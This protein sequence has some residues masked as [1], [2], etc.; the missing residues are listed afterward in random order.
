MLVLPGARLMTIR[1]A[2]AYL[3]FA[4]AAALAAG[5]HAVAEP[6]VTQKIVTYDVTGTTPAEVRASLNQ[7]GPVDRHDSRRYDANTNWYVRWR[8]QYSNTPQGCAIASVTS[9]VEIVTTMPKLKSDAGTPPELARA[10]SA[11][12]EKLTEHERGHGQNGIA[13][14]RLIEVAIRKHPPMPSCD[15]LGQSANLLGMKIIK[16]DGARMDMDYDA[17]TRHGRT[18]GAIF[19]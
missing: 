4:A 11:Y 16:E 19:P 15:A 18:Q 1:N 13:V 7:L 8:Y 17:R 3:L 6:A 9:S 2:V 5:S 14:A 12:T 10:F